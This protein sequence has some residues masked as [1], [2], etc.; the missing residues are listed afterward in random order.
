M[1]SD[2]EQV[3]V[4]LGS[5]LK[6]ALESATL[7]QTVFD[8]LEADWGTATPVVMIASAGAS[9]EN[10]TSQGGLTAY[11]YDVHVY[12]LYATEDGT[13]TPTQSQQRL[14]KIYSAIAAFVSA[15]ANR[16]T[17]YWKTI[18]QAAESI[19]MPEAVGGVGYWHEMIP[20]RVQ[21]A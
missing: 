18:R 11:L 1:S 12:V 13:W 16:H 10:L 15:S 8:H 7:A 2:R 19:V 5:L 6:T 17:A 14:D 4:Q 21:V 9:T 20:I 3:R